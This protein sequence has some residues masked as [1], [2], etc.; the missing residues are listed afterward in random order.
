MNLNLKIMKQ[1]IK[2]IVNYKLDH[3]EYYNR[4]IKAEK[5]S[6]ELVRAGICSLCE[7]M[8]T[9]IIFKKFKDNQYPKIAGRKCKKCGCILSLKIRS[10]SKCPISKW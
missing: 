3:N 8:D 4:E 10:E 2:G 1:V 5:R 9:S 6:L 7:F